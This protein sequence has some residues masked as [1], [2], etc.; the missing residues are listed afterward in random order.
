MNKKNLNENENTKIHN[1]SLSKQRIL[2]DDVEWEF[3][4]VEW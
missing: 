2:C 4:I 3:R 1:D